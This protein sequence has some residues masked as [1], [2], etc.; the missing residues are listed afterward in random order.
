MEC[1]KCHTKLDDNQ[2]VCPRCHKVLLLECPNC[3]NLSESAVC[4]KCGYTIVVKCSKCGKINPV[5]KEKCSKCGFPVKTSL[6]YQECESDDFASIIV[7]FGALKNIRRLLKSQELY[8]KFYYRLKN[9]LLAQLKGVDCKLI[10]YN[11]VFVINMNKELSFAT[12]SNKAARLAIKVV[13]AFSELNNN[14]VEELSSPLNLSL[15]IVK[16]SSE[17]LQDLIEYENNVKLL[18][19][20]I[21]N[22]CWD[23]K[24]YWIKMSAII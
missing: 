7:K 18:N 22:T 8:S 12:S 2:T 15:T 9:L 6:A 1:P 4:E 17:N 16:K 20:L 23:S 5:T 19:N 3:K 24:L 11:D 10:I 13:N 21:K 14:I